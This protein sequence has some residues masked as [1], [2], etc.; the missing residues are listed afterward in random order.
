MIQL[1]HLVG[2]LVVLLYEKMVLKQSKVVLKQPKVLDNVVLVHGVGED[3][4]LVKH[5]HPLGYRFYREWRLC[6]INIVIIMIIGL[7][8]SY[9]H[10]IRK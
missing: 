4:V 5:E 1:P 3:F 9:N 7:N 2:C 8:D 10:K 6:V